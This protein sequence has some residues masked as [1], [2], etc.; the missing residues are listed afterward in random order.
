M[1]ADEKVF[2]RQ[3]FEVLRIWPREKLLARLG[4]IRLQADGH[5]YSTTSAL[6]KDLI[7]LFST[8]DRY[9]LSRVIDTVLEFI[10]TLKHLKPQ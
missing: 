9:E 4:E 3:I 5:G 10:T 7:D 8:E 6:C 2:A 1:E